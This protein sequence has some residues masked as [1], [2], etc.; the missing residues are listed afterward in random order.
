MFSMGVAVVPNAWEDY[1]DMSPPEIVYITRTFPPSVGP[2]QNLAWDL[3]A[4]VS[5]AGSSRRV[6]LGRSQRNLVW[7]LPLAAF[8]TLVALMR[9]QL[10]TVVVGDP[11]VLIVLW[12]VLA[13]RPRARVVVV[14]HDR[15]LNLPS[16]V[17][18]NLCRRAFRRADIVIAISEATRQ[19]AVAFG[20]EPARIRVVLPGLTV[21]A[22]R[23]DVAAARVEVRARTGFDVDDVVVATLGRLV[24]C[25]GQAWFAA[26]VLPLLPARYR[27][28]AAGDGPDQSAIIAAA[29]A[30]GVGD[31]CVVLGAVDAVGREAVLSGA[32]VFVVP[33]ISV[34][35]DMEGLGLVAAEASLRGTPVVAAR[36]EGLTDTV[37]E[38][39][40]GT[41]CE[42]GD[43]ETFA[44]AVRAIVEDDWA[45][46]EW[47]EAAALAAAARYG[48]ERFR[49]DVQGILA[50]AKPRST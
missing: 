15:E 20:I 6:A 39:V 2:M 5:Q 18:L 26:E 16:R 8:R 49:R 40:T 21:P 36:L 17:T 3:S 28:L 4:G 34:P 22:S 25:K 50:P 42:S 37:V 48:I 7:F 38:G 31:R 46:E 35:T 43:A 14:I 13:L 24:P 12:P 45:D 10:P 23:P 9:K 47:R 41:T 11:V 29:E 32:D 1:L 27:Y 30:A 19:E 33:N 44:A